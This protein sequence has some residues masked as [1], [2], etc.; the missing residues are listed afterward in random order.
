MIFTLEFSFK[1]FYSKLIEWGAKSSYETPS[2]LIYL[3]VSNVDTIKENPNLKII[4]RDRDKM[5]IA[6]TRWEIFT[7]EMIKLSNQDVKIYEISGNDE[8]A[9][10]AIMNRSQKV[11]DKGIHL[12]YESKIVTN[13]SLKRSVYL[14]P[15]EEL[16]DFIKDSKNKNITI[17]HVY[18][19]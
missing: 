7:Q 17:E 15:V 11:N 12:L 8:I 16:L 5:I 14:L 4:R 6:V 2:N 18:D 3:I 13:D 1:A 10:S 19:Y 9:V